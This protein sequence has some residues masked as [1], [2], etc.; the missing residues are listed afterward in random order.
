M[1]LQLA[2]NEAYVTRQINQSVYSVPSQSIFNNTDVHHAICRA[3][4]LVE[5]YLTIR[6]LSTHTSTVTMY[7]HHTELHNNVKQTKYSFNK[8]CF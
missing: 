2:L 4:E 1:L 8:L 6:M 7:I 5:S 3:I